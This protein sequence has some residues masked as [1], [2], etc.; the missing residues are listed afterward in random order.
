[1][2]WSASP[3]RFMPDPSRYMKAGSGMTFIVQSRVSWLN[4]LSV[5]VTL[6]WSANPAT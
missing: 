4:G 6:L 1:M 3:V 2:N 5:L